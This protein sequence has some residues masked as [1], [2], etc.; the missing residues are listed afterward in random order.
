M[1]IN[2]KKKTKLSL[3]GAILIVIGQ[4]VGIGIFFKNA[5]I[6]NNNGF[7][8]WGVLLSWLIGG[9]LTICVA[10]TIANLVK[11][12]QKQYHTPGIGQW[13][14]YN[15]GWKDG[16][17]YNFIHELFLLFFIEFDNINILCRSFILCLWCT[18]KHVLIN[19]C[20]F[21]SFSF[22]IQFA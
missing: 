6:F 1:K 10:L 12:K 20:M 15:H 3:M 16:S 2:F 18:T 19:M 13:V 21:I 5:S 7:S 11:V 22:D 9:F 17:L 8:G 4:I 14:K